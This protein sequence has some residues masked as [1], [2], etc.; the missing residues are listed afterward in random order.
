MWRFG[1]IAFVALWGAGVAVAQS[2]RPSP[3]P[4]GANQQPKPI[5][6]PAQ[7]QSAA[8]QR[9]TDD[10]PLIV[11]VV[12][13]PKTEQEAAQDQAKRDDES[14]AN[15]WMVRLTGIIAIIGLIQAFVFWVQAGRLKGTITKMD[16]IATGQTND[17]QDSIAQAGRAAVAMENVA[18]SM[19]ENVENLKITVGINREIADRQRLVTELQSRA[20]LSIQFYGMVP[21][22]A[23]TGIR[24][25]PR[26]NLVNLGN[27]PAYDVVSRTAAD[28]LP[29]PLPEDFAFPLPAVVPTRSVS[30][31][32]PRLNKILSAVVPKIYPDV[33]VEQLKGGVGQRIHIWGEV[34]YKDAFG[35]DR[36]VRFSQSFFWLSDGQNVMS[37]DTNRYNDA[38]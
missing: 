36:Y 24:F 12:P 19:A 20:Y 16:E 18:R 2:N 31:I 21:Q 5:A 4:G 28:V 15:W 34:F 26:I 32:A 27:T 7:Q 35:I 13:A 17:M 10:A 23:A 33:E 37:S 1:I 9:G 8:D 6:Q 29:T 30:T 25:E 14:A 38:N 22:N 3:G 11:R